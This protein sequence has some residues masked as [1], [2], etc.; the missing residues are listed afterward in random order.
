MK[1]Q[2]FITPI[3][4][5]VIDFVR[6]LRDDK[7]L[8]QQD[9]AAIVGV[10]REFIKDVENLNKRAKYNIRHINALA[11]YL[12]MSPRDF[13]PEKPMRLSTEKNKERAPQ[14]KKTAAKKQIRRRPATTKKKE[15]N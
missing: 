5:F 4:Q 9:V 11:D 7:G 12:D 2:E 8:R 13:L 15:S 3:D 6:K 14:K 10:S 1:D